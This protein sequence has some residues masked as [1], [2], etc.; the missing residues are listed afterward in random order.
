LAALAPD[1]IEAGDPYRLAWSALDAASARGVPCV[2][3][4]HSNIV[5]EAQHRLGRA[6]AAAARLYLRR[7]FAHFDAVF[8]ASRWMVDGLRDLG[9]D[10]VVRQPLGVDVERF[11]PGCRDDGWRERLGI[12][13]DTIVLAY[14]GRYAS[15]KNLDT[16]VE[17]VDRLGD[18]YLLV[19][20]GAG[21]CVPRGE[22]VRVLPYS[23][24]PGA[25]ATTLASADVFV[26]AGQRETFGLAAL[27]ALACG[28]PIVVP[29][30]AGLAELCDGR[31]AIGVDGG[32]AA[33]AE[34]VRAL[35]EQSRD[36][37]RHFAV[38][39]AAAF[40]QRQTFARL[41][42][43]YTALRSTQP[44]NPHIGGLHLA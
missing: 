36:S 21:P 3:F 17:V 25:I 6:T 28:T 35:R 4:C 2:T 9:L 42:E 31:A 38:E 16:L 5:A 37:L 24:E 29:R 26:H 10:N 7:L 43:R 44:L 19:L 8:A 1:V 30:S 40:D 41:F 14:A 18:P 15:E 11:N 32:V 33:F 12:P 34:A 22:R 13:T 20:Q 39:A 23:A 27:E